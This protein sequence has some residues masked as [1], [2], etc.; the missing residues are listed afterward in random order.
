[1]EYTISDDFN[2]SVDQYWEV[3]FSEAYNTELWPALDIVWEPAK[4][5]RKGEGKDLV[6]ERESKLTPKREVP[7]LL[8]KLVKGAITYVERNTY[9]ASTSSMETVTIPNFG[10]DRID[11]HGVYKIV[12]AGSGK[13]T[14][15]WEGYCKCKIPLLGGKVEQF[16]VGEIK[17]SYRR[18]TEFT[19]DFHRRNA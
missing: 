9:R 8:K 15:I 10:A 1:M 7:A 17:E 2:V 19:R 5:E 12:D 18:A 3:F 13:C 14:R 16:L 6:I 4:F 11:N